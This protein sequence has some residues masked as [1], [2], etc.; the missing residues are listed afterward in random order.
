MRLFSRLRLT[1]KIV[2]LVTLL[3][4]LAVIIM[5]YSMTS[6]YS[7][8]RDYRSLLDNDAEASL[9]ISAALL[10]LSD[11]S[12]MVLSVLTEQEVAEMRA[13]QA[14]LR[15]QRS[16]FNDKV[17]RIAPLLGEV[18]L[19]L[20]NLLAQEQR[21]FA[22]ADAIIDSAARWRGDKA[23]KIIQEEFEPQ[24]NALR[25]DMDN[26]RDDTVNHFQ[27]ASLGLNQATEDT[28]ANTTLL[29][30]LALVGIIG[31]S[32]Y[33]SL[34]Q[35]SR[36]I[37]QL[38]RAMGRLTTRDYKQPI[39]HTERN[40]EVG[41]M[42]Q[43]LEVFRDNMQRADRLEVEA[44]ASARARELAEKVAE[45]KA[46]FLATMSHE[47][48]TPMNAI[49]GLA[50]LSLRHPLETRQRDR[51]EKIM[52]TG[53]HLLGI[54]NSILDYS[55][56][57]GGHVVAETI[58]FSP[59]QLLDDVGEM[60]AVNAEEKGLSLTV[61]AQG[62]PSVLVGDPMRI[63]QIFLNYCNN[64]VKFSDHGRISVRMTLQQDADHS[65]Y[66]YGEVE[67][68]GIG[69]DEQQ[70][71]A[72]F[73]PFSQADSS[74]SRRFGGTGL[75]LAISRNLA[76][77]MGGTTGVRSELGEGSTFWFRVKVCHPEEH[78]A[79]PAAIPA[80]QEVCMQS[81][82]GLRLLLVD[83]NE[84][85][86]LVAR[87]LLMEEGILVDE[88]SNGWQ[89]LDLLESAPDN[90]FGMVLMDMMMPEL[91][92]LSTTRRLRRNPRFETI[93]IIAMTANASTQDVKRCIEAGM[94][95]HVSKPIDQPILFRTLVGQRLSALGG[96]E[97]EAPR[98]LMSIP[99][100][101]AGTTSKVLDPKPL[102]HLKKLVSPERF[103]WM[104][105]M[106]IQD[107]RQ[108]GDVFKSLASQAEPGQFQQHAH[109]LIG[110][111]G[112]VGLNQLRDLGKA[113]KAASRDVDAQITPQLALDIHRATRDAIEA[114]QA[115]FNAGH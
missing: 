16:R 107:C 82:R 103:D 114:L 88:A 14:Q 40:D 51:I 109:D 7:V 87:E 86:R 97:T 10:D 20:E 54:I 46:N 68:Q 39:H 1:S 76:E 18:N 37:N 45:A 31:L 94:N 93:P 48:R 91:D 30:T 70:I 55:A 50:Q 74:I 58:P 84:L 57:D 9:L 29:F 72:L 15:I 27:S 8:S 52:R 78:D 75:G 43:A 56:I 95:A 83:D 33:L 41:E 99:P 47:I 101:S 85:N 32:A 19:E 13:T 108:R 89:A 26:L 80:D 113:M 2:L 35:I 115:R 12:K 62:C 92:G 28:I 102:E 25:Q 17:R 112:H 98:V 61:E 106:L 90:T 44:A 11:A 60:L 36:P 79:L 104:L 3:G 24:L 63:S 73:Q 34:T 71:D 49:L 65:L 64:A 110:A 111:A 38:T 4:A 42:A 23:L 69:L 21:L 6:L 77:L 105:E 81:L 67:D 53:E 22:L 66:L 59:Q 100:A 5:L 96:A